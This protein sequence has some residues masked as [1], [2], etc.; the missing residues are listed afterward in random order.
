MSLIRAIVVD[1][2]MA[3]IN[4]VESHQADISEAIVQVEANGIFR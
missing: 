3:A 2:S 1:S 4:E